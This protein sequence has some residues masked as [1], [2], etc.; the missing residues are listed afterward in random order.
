MKKTFIILTS[1]LLIC[2]ML[3]GCN[4]TDATIQASKELN[5]N[6]AHIR[7]CCR[8]ERK[9]CSDYTWRYA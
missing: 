1:L 7:D 3:I 5:I 6:S 4:S 9:H 2:I 8:G